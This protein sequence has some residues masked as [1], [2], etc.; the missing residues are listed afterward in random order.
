MTESIIIPCPRCDTLNR[1]PAGRLADG[2][3]CGACKTPLFTGAPLT[4]TTARFDIHARAGLPLLADFWA[5]WCGPCKA[6][7]PVF[8][9]AAREMEPRLRFAKVDTEAEPHLAARHQIRSIPTLVLFRA[10][11]EV[12]R[13]SGA[14]PAGELRRWI[15]AHLP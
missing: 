7:A 9:G 8:E 4:L 11:H 2:G 12:A 14:L 15:A 13:V 1:L 6:M 3:K 5:A 10:G